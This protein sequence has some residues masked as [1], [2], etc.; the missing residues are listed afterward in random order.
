[1]LRFFITSMLLVFF[2]SVK[3]Q[4]SQPDTVNYEPVTELQSVQT[5]AHTLIA[6]LMVA[7]PN[8][9]FVIY[10]STDNGAT[11]DSVFY[12][13]ADADFLASPDPVL[14][15]DA[16]GNIY[17]AVMRTQPMAGGFTA[18]MWIYKSTDDGLTWTMS[19]P[20]YADI[21]FADYPSITSLGDGLVYHSYTHYTMDTSYITFKRSFDGTATWADST[22]F[23]AL[24]PPFSGYDAIGSDLGWSKEN[25]LC[26]SYGDY[27]Y[28]V[29]YFTYS[30]DSGAAWTPVQTIP[31]S[32]PASYIITK[33][34]SHPQ[35]SHVG[36]IAH[37]PHWLTNVY[38][39]TSLDTG[40]SWQYQTI[41]TNSAYCEGELDSAGNVHL[42]YN[43][44]IPGGSALYYRYS[45]DQG[46]SFTAPLSLLNWTVPS[47]TSGE[48]QS[49]ILGKDNLF[50]LT[51]VDWNDFG[52]A[53]HLI[54][55][56]MLTSIYAIDPDSD[57]PEIFPNPAGDAITIRC[58]SSMKG[59]LYEVMDLAGKNILMGELAQETTTVKTAALPGAVYL[60]RISKGSRSF[61]QKLLKK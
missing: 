39:L 54:F 13:G 9:Y 14:T 12:Y 5:P 3:A 11:W 29:V 55:A 44:E 51:Y 26:L 18:H 22:N 33:V 53:R 57:A 8:P 37:Q 25:R 42:I 46:L 19:T 56:P 15:A 28:D 60:V 40:N 31:I 16:A 48:Y 34:V 58:N 6:A 50:H 35:Y 49:L 1:M 30:R 21:D 10:R 47:F 43:E 41:S 38:Y 59:A 17:V 24:P 36:I 27:N 45:T 61:I 52:E 23:A 7:A 2:M 4:V 20:S 32:S